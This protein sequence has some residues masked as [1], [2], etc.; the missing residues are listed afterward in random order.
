[1]SR[2]AEKRELIAFL[3]NRIAET[4]DDYE[5][6]RYRDLLKMVENV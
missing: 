6:H 4:K 2:P 3:K 5:R 1:M